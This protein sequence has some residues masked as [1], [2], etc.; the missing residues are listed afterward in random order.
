MLVSKLK[1]VWKEVTLLTTWIATVTGA[2][3]IPLPAW[4][5]SDQNTSF[6]TKFGVFIATVIAG[7]LILFSLK[8]KVA[9]T[10]M[11][12]SIAFFILFICSYTTYHF[13]REAKTLPYVEKDIIIGNTMV[14]N[15]P[16]EAF[17]ASHGFLPARKE[18][19]MILLGDPEKA[20]TKQSI[21]SNR[22]LLMVFLF[23]CYL[24]SAGFMISFCNLI[25]LYKEKYTIKLVKKEQE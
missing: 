6:L 4:Y 1:E 17:E 13:F 23:L 3:I 16:F 18:R 25:I 20:W 8:N 2:F 12:L 5:S 14:E 15:N 7:F 10:W 19:M 24:F 21:M 11:R 22:I 9:K